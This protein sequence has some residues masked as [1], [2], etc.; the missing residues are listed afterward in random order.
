MTM[1][2]AAKEQAD[3]DLRLEGRRVRAATMIQSLWRAYK[4]RRQIHLK[5]KLRGKKKK[6][7]KGKKKGKR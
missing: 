4:V 7:K 5:E 6:K 1:R 3:V 2:K